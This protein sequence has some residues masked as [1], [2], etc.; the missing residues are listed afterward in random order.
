[1]RRLTTHKATTQVARKQVTT[2]QNRLWMHLHEAKNEAD[3]VDT[4]YESVGTV[5]VPDHDL[6]TLEP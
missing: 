6:P 4:V 3:S 1:M 2:G 5:V